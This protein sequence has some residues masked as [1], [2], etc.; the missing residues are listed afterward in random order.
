MSLGF[1]SA[2]VIAGMD[3]HLISRFGLL[4]TRIGH[5]DGRSSFSI[6]H[7]WRF[8]ASRRSL[9]Y[10]DK[11]GYGGNSHASGVSYFVDRCKSCGSH[12]LGLRSWEVIG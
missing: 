7:V 6:H 3:S 11:H 1:G 8:Y 12:G 5:R 10:A 9:C 4:L 2:G